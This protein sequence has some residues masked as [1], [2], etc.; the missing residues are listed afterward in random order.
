MLFMVGN[1]AKA[2]RLTP[3]MQMAATDNT[4]FCMREK[5]QGRVMFLGIIHRMVKRT[6]GLHFCLLY[7]ISLALLMFS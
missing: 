4:A 1:S 2:V 3:T 7:G 6:L 5:E